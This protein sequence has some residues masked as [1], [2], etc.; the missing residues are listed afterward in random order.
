MNAG[1]SNL[2]ESVIWMRR[3]I[4]RRRSTLRWSV[5]WR[6]SPA[7]RWSWRN[8]RQTTWP[9]GQRTLVDIAWEAVQSGREAVIRI[10][11]LEITGLA[12]YARGNLMSIESSFGMVEVQL[13]CIDSLQIASSPSAPGRSVPSEAESFV[14]RL[15]MLQL[16]N[17]NVEV[18]CRGGQSRFEGS[19]RAVGR[20]HIWLD[21]AQGGVFVV[22]DSVAFVI[23]RPI[24][25]G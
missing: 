22:I 25:S 18:V 5:A 24:S 8:A 15:S 6:R 12:V 3:Q 4:L 7:R 16:A 13:G 9:R 10:G 1:T 2:S 11:R 21:T 14:A 23:R 17:E 20:D 19:V